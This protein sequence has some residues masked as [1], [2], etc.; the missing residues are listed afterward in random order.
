MR[1]IVR[2]GFAKIKPLRIQG[3][4]EGDVVHFSSK[5]TKI[6][7]ENP[8]ETLIASLAACELGTLKAISRSS[9]LKIN[10]V[11]FT[12][13][14]SGLNIEKFMKG[15]PEDKIEDISIEAEIDTNVSQ[16]ELDQWV[17][18]ALHSCPVYQM[19]T[20]AGVKIDSKWKKVQ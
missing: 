14:E 20:L 13:I 8:L 11:K 18:K 6:E 9:N 19:L 12:K 3:Q 17:K 2:F 16:E 10:K 15:G 5:E 4:T 1:N 7:T